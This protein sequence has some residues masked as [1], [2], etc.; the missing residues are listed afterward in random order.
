[1]ALTEKQKFNIQQLSV[2][3]CIEILD[4]CKERLGIVS[5]VEYIKII[6]Y[7]YSRENLVQDMKK[8]KIKYYEICGRRFPIINSK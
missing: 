6:N 4:E 3:D 5:Q 7:P 2:D 1:M 8:G